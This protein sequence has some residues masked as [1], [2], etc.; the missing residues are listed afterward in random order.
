MARLEV[1]LDEWT[2]RG[3]AV[4]CVFAQSLKA[5]DAFATREGL[6]FPVFADPERRM[7][8]DYGVYVRINFESWN[9]ARPTV[10]LVDPAGIVREVFGGR[11]SLEWPDSKDLWALMERHEADQEIEIRGV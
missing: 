3:A 9:M 2:R 4:A 6:P 11:H 7:V 8:R 1:E 10:V 5:V